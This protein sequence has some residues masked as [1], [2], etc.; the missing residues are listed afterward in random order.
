[1]AERRPV[2]VVEDDVDLRTLLSELLE[3]EGYRVLVAENGAS[4]IDVL[5]RTPD[6]G[7]I[8]L[9]LMM[10]VMD[11]YQFRAHQ[12]RDPAMAAIPVILL[13][14][15]GNAVQSAERLGVVEAMTKPV[16]LDRLLALVARYC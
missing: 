12:V 2:L 10:P 14:A 7:L 11:G 5:R 3:T 13:T 9:D 4:A 15:D 16:E 8:L 6:V 1:V